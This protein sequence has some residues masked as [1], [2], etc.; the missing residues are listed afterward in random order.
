MHLKIQKQIFIMHVQSF[1]D[2]N[3]KPEILAT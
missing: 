3:Q 1:Y 2:P